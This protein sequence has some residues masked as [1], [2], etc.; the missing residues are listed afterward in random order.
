MAIHNNVVLSAIMRQV[1]ATR[2]PLPTS[3]PY[4]TRVERVPAGNYVEIWFL[5][6]GCTWDSS[7]GC[8][9]CNY[10]A[11]PPVSPTAM[12]DAVRDALEELTDE[13]DELMISPSGGMWD[14]HEVTEAAV[15]QMYGLARAARP[16][17]FFV[18]TRAET[19][20]EARVAEMR[21]ALPGMRL[22]VEVGLE[23]SSEAVLRYCVN[24]G[25]GLDTYLAAS[26]VLRPAGVELYAN[27]SLGTAFL[28]H[29]EAVQDAVWTAR[30]ALENGADRVVVFPLHIKP[31]TLLDA[32][33][34]HGLYQPVSLWDLVDVLA[35]LGSGLSGRVEIAWYKSYYD[36]AAKISRSPV[37][38]ATCT[39]WLV[40][41]L[42]RY[43]ATQDFAVV[44]EL[45]GR[46]CPCADARTEP[47]TLDGDLPE[48]VWRFHAR[49][50]EMYELGQLWGRYAERYRA[51]IER[52]FEDYAEPVLTS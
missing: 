48:R 40:D 45:L 32:L 8:T 24:K 46:R 15:T 22:A 19:V 3:Q 4:F 6:T 5:T 17:K 23:S 11:G 34:G 51:D 10:G 31:Y 12:V 25:S 20:S 39:A 33:A 38:C 14:K 50:T 27:V 9:M 52:A 29:R 2:P 41:G 18:E 43:R 16:G 7:G 26:G 36:T 44:E 49:L 37:G 30:W 13:P 35:A 42:D 21:E 47:P 28:T 1:R